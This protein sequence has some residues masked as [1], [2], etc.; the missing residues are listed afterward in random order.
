MTDTHNDTYQQL[1]A[2]GRTALADGEA[3]KALQHFR[4]ALGE[5]DDDPE[6]Y[7]L[8][9]TAHAQATTGEWQQR[10]FT[11][12]LDWEMRKQ[13]LLNPEVA[14][15]HERLLPPWQEVTNLVN[16]LWDTEDAEQDL[17]SRLA[18]REHGTDAIL[19]LL[20]F[21]LHIRNSARSQK[22]DPCTT[23]D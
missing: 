10:D 18:I 13:A 16:T 2:K 4:D 17:A 23:S 3:H 1:L 7:D 6:L 8:L 15:T 11:E 9:I 5:R 19:P 21:I 12:T 14:M 20:D 22:D